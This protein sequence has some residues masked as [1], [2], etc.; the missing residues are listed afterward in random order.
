[1]K[2]VYFA[3]ADIQIARVDRQSIVHFCSALREIGVDVVLVA[4][5]IGL[6][7]VETQRGDPL[8]LYRIGSPFPV[9]TI[10]VPVRQESH[11]W[12]IALNRL[13]AYSIVGVREAGRG[14][15]ASV[16]YVKNYGPALVFL[17]LRTLRLPVQLVFEAHVPPRNMMQRLALRNAALVVANTHALASDLVA[18]G[19]VG[20]NRVIATHQGVDLDRLNA[21]RISRAEAR[22]GLDLPEDKE[23]VVYTGK[24]YRGYR[25]VEYILEA[26]KR[27]RDKSSVLFV[28]VGGR[29]DHVSDIRKQAE[30]EGSTNVVFTGFIPPTVVPRYQFAADILLLYYPSGM[31]LNK[32]RSPGKLFEYLAVGR[33]IVAADLPVLQEVLGEEPA[34]VLVRQDD[35]EA[36]ATAISDLL[37]DEARAHELS[38][39]GLALAAGF[40][41]KKRAESIV[42]AIEQRVANSV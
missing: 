32:Y 20:A 29:A 34:A 18:R 13:V 17:V 26:A 9:R 36:L 25:E 12:W 14:S 6:L 7:D 30:A 19:D 10:R 4:L 37:G 5:R 22:R 3:P 41:W 11:G 21:E 23:L 42:Q 40:T 15:P 39:R 2:L 38:K 31:E 35:P 24:I 1:M 8:E 33:P 28:L 27:F 16:F